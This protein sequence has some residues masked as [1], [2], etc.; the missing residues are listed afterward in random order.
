MTET[1]LTFKDDYAA[2]AWVMDYC[3]SKGYR[4]T[5]KRPLA[6]NIYVQ[7][8]SMISPK[9]MSSRT[10]FAALQHHL[11]S[12]QYL[13]CLREGAVKNNIRGRDAGVV[14]AEEAEQARLKL[15]KLHPDY[16]RQQR[17]KRKPGGRIIV[18]TKKK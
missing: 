16:L 17:L 13:K 1:K 14:T 15:A 3:K 6:D 8:R 2:M 12:I 7:L 10:L 11:N 5:W 9:V 18:N 4:V